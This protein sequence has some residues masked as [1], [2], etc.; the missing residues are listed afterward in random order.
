MTVLLGLNSMAT[1]RTILSIVGL[2]HRQRFVHNLPV[3]VAVTYAPKKL[4]IQDKTATL[5]DLPTS[6]QPVTFELGTSWAF[7]H[8]CTW[9]VVNT[10]RRRHPQYAQLMPG[11]TSSYYDVIIWGPPFCISCSR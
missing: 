11:T 6:P 4:R 7:T 10:H 9:Q 2:R 1:L 5:C 3:S 8:A